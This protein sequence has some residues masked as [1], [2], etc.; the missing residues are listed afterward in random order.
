MTLTLSYQPDKGITIDSTLLLWNT[1]RRN[2]RQLLNESFEIADSVIDL[3]KYNNGDMSRNIIQR[4]DIYTNFKGLDSYFFLNYDNEDKLREIEIH[5]GLEIDINGEKVSF[6]MDID[7]V[8]ELLQVISGDK[9]QLSGG[10]YLFK[11]LKLTVASGE[12][13]GGDGNE[14]SYFYCS[15]DITHLID[16]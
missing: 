12:V 11:N 10:E 15:K 3:S 1:D 8:V 2:V 14:L 13:M 6:S 16:E 4:R 5:N 7:K 9:I